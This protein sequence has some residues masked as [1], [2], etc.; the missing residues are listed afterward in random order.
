LGAALR[1][2]F[3][4]HRDRAAIVALPILLMF[5]ALDS[6]LYRREA[7]PRVPPIRIQLLGGI[8]FV[9][10]ALIIGAILGSATW[11]PGVSID[12]YGTHLAMHLDQIHRTPG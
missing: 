4:V 1:S 5:L 6:L 3:V 11:Q 10:I 2:P 7:R 12:V 8:N 9:L